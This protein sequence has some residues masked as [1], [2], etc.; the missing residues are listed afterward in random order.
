[1]TLLVTK[2]LKPAPA[3]LHELKLHLSL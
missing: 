1:M 2:S 3:L